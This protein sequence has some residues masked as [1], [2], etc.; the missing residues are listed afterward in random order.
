MENRTQQGGENLCRSVTVRSLTSALAWQLHLE[1]ASMLYE[2]LAR[3]T[4]YQYHSMIAVLQRMYSPMSAHLL[5]ERHFKG[6]GTHKRLVITT[7]VSS[8][9]ERTGK[10]SS[11]SEYPVR[12][13]SHTSLLH[14]PRIPL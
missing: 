7:M 4:G 5:L 14:C 2:Y 10:I 13:P 9:H 6:F 11:V 3:E 1:E 12:C 8:D